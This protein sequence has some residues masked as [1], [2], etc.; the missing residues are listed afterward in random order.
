MAMVEVAKRDD[1]SPVTLSDIADRL[2]LSLS[3]LEQLFMKLRRAGLVR[4]VRGPGG[5]Y[6]LSRAAR[7]ISIA[8]VMSAVDE[9]VHMTRC[10]TEGSVGCI[11]SKRCSTHNLWDALGGHIAE[12]LSGATLADVTTG[13][14]AMT[15]EQ[16][17]PRKL[18]SPVEI[19]R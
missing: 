8:E 18:A 12:F 17:P 6:L 9:P 4:S 5:G 13:R 2:E 1:A 15:S 7:S 3:Y 10:G 16:S 14:F 11:A 19:E